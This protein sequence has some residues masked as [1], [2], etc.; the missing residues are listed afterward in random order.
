[1]AVALGTWVR[2]RLR[3]LMAI[4]FFTKCRGRNP[5]I[6]TSAEIEIRFDRESQVFAV[7]EWWAVKWPNLQVSPKRHSLPCSAF[8]RLPSFDT[9]AFYTRA[10][11]L[12]PRKSSAI[13]RLIRNAV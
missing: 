8:A 5:A 12:D 3:W 9:T 4:P 13:S 7:A 2:W 6:R 10:E 11:A 1:M